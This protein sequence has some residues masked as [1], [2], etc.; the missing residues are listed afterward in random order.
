MSKIWLTEPFIQAWN[1][2]NPFDEIEKLT[3]QIF[4]EVKSRRT[5]RFEFDGRSY[6]IKIHR[7]IGWKEIFKDLLQFRLPILSAKNEWKAIRKAEKLGILSMVP[8]A[9]GIHGCNPA[10]LQSF[11]VTEE[12]K[13]VISLE[14]MG[15]GWIHNP[16][17]YELKTALIKKVATISQRLHNNGVNHRDYYLCHFLIDISQGRERIDPNMIKLYLIDLH[18]AQIRK[19]T[20]Y[21]WVLKDIAGLYFSAMNIGLTKKDIFRFM[22]HYSGKSLRQTI[23]EDEIFWNNVFHTAIALYKKEFDRNPLTPF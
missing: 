10:K 13:N 16:P 21:R 12:I 17:S 19:E 4:R 20:P 5:L 22:K 23:A 18:R 1:D 7:G 8:T 3:G 2:K 9:F 15:M 11:I 6:F 14:E